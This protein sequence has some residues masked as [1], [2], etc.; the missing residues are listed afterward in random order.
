[1]LIKLDGQIDQL[2]VHND[3]FGGFDEVK[4]NIQ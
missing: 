4:N 3:H 2:T 1:M